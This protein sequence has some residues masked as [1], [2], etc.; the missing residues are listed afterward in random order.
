MSANYSSRCYFVL[1]FLIVYFDMEVGGE[2][3]G[4]IEF[5]LR[6]DVVPKTAEN[7]RQL[8]SHVRACHKYK[9]KAKRRRCGWTNSRLLFASIIGHSALAKPAL[10]TRA[11]PFTVSFLN[12]CARGTFTRHSSRFLFNDI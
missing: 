12:S 7:F 1:V 6:A 10:D 2:D 4:R 8:V 11:V 3:I 5:E 9:D